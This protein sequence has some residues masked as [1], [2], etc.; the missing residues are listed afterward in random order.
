MNWEA[1]IWFVI[2]AVVI[3]AG[4]GVAAWIV[5]AVLAASNMRRI[6]KSIT[7]QT[8]DPFDAPFFRRNRRP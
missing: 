6:T 5:I 8:D 2:W 4:L 7:S 3:L 1:V